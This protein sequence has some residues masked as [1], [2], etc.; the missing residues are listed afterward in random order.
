MDVATFVNT[1]EPVNQ[2]KASLHGGLVRQSGVFQPTDKGFQTRAQKLH[3][4]KSE[5]LFSGA[6]VKQLREAMRTAD[7]KVLKDNNFFPEADLLFSFLQDLR[8][9]GKKAN[10]TYKLDDEL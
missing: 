9:I 3:Y 6:V 10:D 4:N 8:I 7:V 1:L 2:L 5:A